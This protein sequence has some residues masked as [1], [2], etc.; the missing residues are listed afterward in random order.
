MDFEKWFDGISKENLT[1]KTIKELMALAYKEGAIAF[2]KES[3]LYGRSVATGEILE[4]PREDNPSLLNE[5]EWNED[6]VDLESWLKDKQVK[7]DSK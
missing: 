2:E 7:D 4:I 1:N 5:G 3:P 6:D